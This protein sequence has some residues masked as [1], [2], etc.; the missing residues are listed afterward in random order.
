MTIESS[1]FDAAV[2]RHHAAVFRTARRVVRG[3]ADAGDV[4]QQ[5]FL[6]AWR[7]TASLGG[8]D[9]EVQRRL[10]WLCSRLALNSLRADR[11][12]RHRELETAMNPTAASRAMSA[13]ETASVRT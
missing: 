12:R 10:C 4:T 13:D 3:D 8:D 1:A 5:V 6:A 7:G 9:G 11:R 2:R